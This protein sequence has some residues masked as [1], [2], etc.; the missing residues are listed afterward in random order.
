MARNPRLAQE[1]LSL[2]A[3][4]NN[5]SISGFASGTSSLPSIKAG[6]RS[7]NSSGNGIPVYVIGAKPSLVKQLSSTEAQ[8][9]VLKKIWGE[10][11]LKNTEFYNSFGGDTDLKTGKIKVGEKGIIQTYSHE[12]AHS[13]DVKGA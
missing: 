1:I 12:R 8:E 2:I 7:G 4:M 3:G 11:S 13:Y 9:T 10:S 5:G 6:L